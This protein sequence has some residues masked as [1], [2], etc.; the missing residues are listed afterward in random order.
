MFVH[1]VVELDEPFDVHGSHQVSG[2]DWL[3][4]FLSIADR[5]FNGLHLI[6]LSTHSSQRSVPEADDIKAMLGQV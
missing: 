2:N 5:G 3:T 1:T 4:F 6:D